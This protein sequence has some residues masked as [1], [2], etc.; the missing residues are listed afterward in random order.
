MLNKVCGSDSTFNIPFE[1]NN[2]NEIEIRA[3]SG[4]QIAMLTNGFEI[5]LLPNDPLS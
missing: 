4:V 2:E 5:G 3:I 1:I